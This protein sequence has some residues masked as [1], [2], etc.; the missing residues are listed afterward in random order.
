MVAEGRRV[1]TGE[2][3]LSGTC[4]AFQDAVELIGR[5]WSG[6]IL[7]A[8][9]GGATRFSE[10]RD[11][12][13]GLSDRLLSARVRSAG[14]G[15]PRRDPDGAGAG[16]LLADRDGPRAA[17]RHQAAGRLEPQVAPP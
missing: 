5:R 10:I 15:R 12:V 6:A 14:S 17:T 11:Q 4:D 7:Y 16:A 13:H 2:A 8:M 9:F 1:A 3:A